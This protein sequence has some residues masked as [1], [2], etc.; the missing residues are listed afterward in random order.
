[1]SKFEALSSKF[2]ISCNGQCMFEQIGSR[3]IQLYGCDLAPLDPTVAS[4]L[5]VTSGGC[6]CDSPP[7]SLEAT[8]IILRPCVESDQKQQCDDDGYGLGFLVKL[9]QDTDLHGACALL[10]VDGKW[11]PFMYRHVGSLPSVT[12]PACSNTPVHGLILCVDHHQ[13]IIAAGMAYANDQRNDIEELL[14]DHFPEVLSY[15]A[16]SLEVLNSP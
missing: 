4:T 13:R 11:H 12:V 10:C 9:R 7:T 1:M 5:T 3:W 6:D 15:V 8:N 16:A 2:V 14:Q